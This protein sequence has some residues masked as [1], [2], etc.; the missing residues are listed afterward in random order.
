[1][2]L[3][4]IPERSF[5]PGFISDMLFEDLAKLYTLDRFSADIAILQVENSFL[6]FDNLALL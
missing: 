1:M 2:G 5:N 6:L 4:I 3:K